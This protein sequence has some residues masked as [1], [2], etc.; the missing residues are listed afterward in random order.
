MSRDDEEGDIE[1]QASRRSVPSSFFSHSTD[2]RALRDEAMSELKF[3]PGIFFRTIIYESF[4]F[5]LPLILCTLMENSHSAANRSFRFGGSGGPFLL[6]LWSGFVC[7][8]LGLLDLSDEVTVYTALT[9]IICTLSRAFTLAV[10]YAFYGNLDIYGGHGLLNQSYTHTDRMQQKLMSVFFYANAV[11]LNLL[12]HVEEIYAT[13]L[14]LDVD[15]Q[16]MELD[17]GSKEIAQ[18]VFT[19]IKAIRKSLSGWQKGVE[20]KVEK[21]M[22]KKTQ[23]SAKKLDGGTEEKVP[24]VNG[25]PS[26]S[27][28]A[29]HSK[30]VV[31]GAMVVEEGATVSEAGHEETKG[32]GE[33]IALTMNKYA[34]NA[35]KDLFYRLGMHFS[36]DESVQEQVERGCVPAT[37]MAILCER[38]GYYL[39]NIWG[40]E[41]F[42]C[43][44]VLSSLVNLVPAFIRIGMGQAAMGTTH[45]SKFLHAGQFLQMD[46]MWWLIFY[47]AHSPV[48]ASY[49]RLRFKKSVTSLISSSGMKFV[50]GKAAAGNEVGNSAPAAVGN[51]IKENVAYCRLDLT[52]ERN[53]VAWNAIRHM[54]HHYAAPMRMKL[55]IYGVISLA[56]VFLI[57]AMPTIGVTVFGIGTF[58]IPEHV[59]NIVRALLVGFSL[60]FSTLYAYFVDYYDMHIRDAVSRNQQHVQA[61]LAHASAADQARIGRLRN[62]NMMLTTTLKQISVAHKAHPEKVL[63]LR[64]DPAVCSLI[65]T[66]LS[67]AL[68]FD[69]IRLQNSVEGYRQDKIGV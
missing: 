32:G 41:F 19:E 6:V 42:G 8:I 7:M 59:G 50:L 49:G 29:V 67:A 53:V 65:V 51:G 2:K 48:L 45:I 63:M 33:R 11:D 54:S 30:Y 64:A 58:P 69:V 21:R 34:E 44:F 36:N 55:N 23:K 5:P 31:T 61:E 18:Q 46:F 57:T 35:E 40:Y 24:A 22:R 43:F 47:Y 26:G 60:I 4:V 13:C 1:M 62:C 66:I 16:H 52:N 68:I 15:L 10:K 28:E 38:R 56:T 17:L 27:H 20:E 37:Y 14:R 3:K 9:C 39:G 12:A 25:L